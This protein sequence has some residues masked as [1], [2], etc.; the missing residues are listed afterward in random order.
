MIDNRQSLPTGASRASTGHL[1]RIAHADSLAHSIGT[2]QVNVLVNWLWPAHALFP[3]CHRR[4]SL[5]LACHHRECTYV[6]PCN[7]RV[8]TRLTGR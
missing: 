1:L 2:A 4:F 6:A 7:S 8:S 5:S 3:H